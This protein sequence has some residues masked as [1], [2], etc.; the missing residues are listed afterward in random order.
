M[1]E[2][3]IF[4]TLDLMAPVLIA[5]LGGL[6]TERAGIL[7][8]AL[9][10]LM[11]TGA[12][13]AVV[14]AGMT[15]SI[16]AGISAALAAAGIF[17]LLFA[18]VGIRLKANIF[19][20]GLAVNLLASGIITFISGKLFSTRGVIRFADFPR[21]ERI[22]LPGGAALTIA[23]PAALILVPLFWYLLY[24]TPFGLRLR[25]AGY[26][27]HVLRSRGVEPEKVQIL[28]VIFSGLACGLAGALLSLRLGAF[29]PGVTAGRG[30]IALVAIFLGRKHPGGILLATFFFALADSLA[31]NAQGLA[32]LPPTLML[33]FPY[34]ITFLALVAGSAASHKSG[35][36]SR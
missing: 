29:V 24:V 32:W 26:N 7:N 16:S 14:V 2:T 25:A 33:A 31:G 34:L 20:A 28:A 3:M 27:Q 36:L 19:I 9:E 1:E 4:N 8:I 23:V 22:H 15:G 13:T 30:W 21:L 6:L 17:A 5:A 10:G 12:F 18:F 35:G 11:L